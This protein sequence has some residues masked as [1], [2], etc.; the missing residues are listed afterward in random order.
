MALL[1]RREAKAASDNEVA[2]SM[3][4]IESFVVR[5]M[6]NAVYTG[7]LNRIFQALTGD[8]A[9]TDDVV[10][11]TR[12][13]LSGARLYWPTDE[14]L[15]EAI[16]TKPFYWQG[17]HPQ[18]VFA[19]AVWRRAFL[20]RSEPIST[21]GTYRSSTFYLKRSRRNGWLRSRLTRRMEKT[22]PEW[23]IVSCRPWET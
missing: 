22:R 13:G 2:E 15:R 17:R 3:L 7:N 21:L 8:I 9:T 5:R 20:P 19:V 12:Q 1:E 4:F 14:E 6:M 16:R 18:R 23:Q 11:A 10:G